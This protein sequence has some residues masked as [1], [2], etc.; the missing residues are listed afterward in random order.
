MEVTFFNKVI[1]VKF[2]L[3]DKLRYLTQF[4]IKTKILK[5]AKLKPFNKSIT[6]SLA[7]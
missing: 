1:C 6:F 5:N 7:R 2:S 3:Y 4:F